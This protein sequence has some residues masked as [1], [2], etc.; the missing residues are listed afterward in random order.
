ME[1]KKKLAIVLSLALM[2]VLIACVLVASHKSKATEEDYAQVMPVEDSENYDPESGIKL[3]PE[4]NG[5]VY[6]EEQDGAAIQYKDEEYSKFVGEWE[7]NSDI[8]NQLY[9]NVDI[10]IN[11]DHTWTGNIT[12]DEYSGECVETDNGLAIKVRSFDFSL[13]FNENGTLIL[14]RHGKDGSS[15]IHTVL[16][17]KTSD[18]GS[19]EG[20][21]EE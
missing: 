5:I 2:A 11:E 19:D 9:G 10:T 12:D 7:A 6:E 4:G 17:R 18:E 3:L 16:I 1:K 13:A 20:S 8:A 21:V 15:D 14:T